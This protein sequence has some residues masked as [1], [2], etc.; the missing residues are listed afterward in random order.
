MFFA[1]LSFAFSGFAYGINT[2]STSAL[3]RNTTNEASSVYFSTNPQSTP[4]SKSL[5]PVPVGLGAYESTNDSAWVPV[6]VTNYTGAVANSPSPMEGNGYGIEG[7]YGGN[8]M[9]TYAAE[10]VSF[11]QFSG[12]TDLG[13][14]GGNSWSVQMN[15]NGFYGNNGDADIYQIVLQN[16][17]WVEHG[18]CPFCW[19]TYYNDF[20]IWQ[21]DSTTQQYPHSTVSIPTYSL[22]T[23]IQ[24]EID[25]YL[26]AGILTGILTITTN[27]GTNSWAVSVTPQY[28]LAGYWSSVSGTIL[29]VGS[30]SPSNP[31]T[32]QFTSP[33]S[34]LTEIV[35]S[36]QIPWSPYA[37]NA[38][39]L[40]YT[41]EQNNLNQGTVQTST[42]WE[43]QY[44]YYGFTVYTYSSN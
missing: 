8:G 34:E 43:P 4:L 15:T 22:S 18:I 25:A 6:N 39:T 9:L 33:T 20:G 27:S 16:N 10:I 31:D 7:A 42:L 1:V 14:G 40:V 11:S 35:A 13:G 21:V 19:K 26:S 5:Q 28:G 37:S 32:A 38:L 36:E 41:V 17:N 23:A 30:T 29:G 24:I 3:A 2:S 44:N 12:E